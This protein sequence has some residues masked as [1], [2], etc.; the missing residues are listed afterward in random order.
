MKYFVY[1]YLNTLKP[2]KFEYENLSFDFEPF[3]VGKGLGKRDLYHLNK[4]KNKNKYKNS[5]KFKII[6]DIISNNYE[7]KIIKIFE[8]CE[9]KDSLLLEK[10][11]ILK[12]GRLDI[13]RGPLTNLN[14]GGLKPQDNYKHSKET[15]LKLSE[16]QRNR[17]SKFYT[18][19]SPSGNIFNNIKLNEFC[20][21]NK[22]DYQKM[23]KFTN[24]GKIF[25]RQ[26]TLAKPETLNCEGWEILNNR[27]NKKQPKK[28]IKYLL[29]SPIGE[30]IKIFTYESVKDIC[31]KLNLNYRILKLYR[32]KGKIKFRNKEQCKNQ[33]SLNCEGWEF[34]DNNHSEHDFDS[35]RKVSWKITSPTGD[36]YYE[37]NLQNF[38]KKNQLSYRTFG[39]FKN[40][41]PI[42]MEIRKNYKIEIINS[43]GWQ[44]QEIV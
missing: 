22:L 35:K 4:V 21:Q 10:E 30:E 8:N 37:S 17:I 5:Q 12:I 1:V 33:D 29:I 27:S 44:C 39:T 11:T 36:I 7:P 26:K 23:R 13:N 16:I 40:R 6:E 31:L 2:G 14:D 25:I 3:Y 19:I 34:I 43:V 32:N 41:G 15:K 18:I 38:C 28:V 24:R 9:E 42:S 20:K